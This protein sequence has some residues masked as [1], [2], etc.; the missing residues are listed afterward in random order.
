RCAALGSNR[1]VDFSISIAVACDSEA[2]TPSSLRAKAFPRRDL[3]PGFATTSSLI[4][5]RAQGMPGARRTH[6]L[7]CKTKKQTSVVTTGTPKS[8]G[9]PCAMALR[10]LRALPG[11]SGLLATVADR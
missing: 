4:D 8:L 3:R 11:V 6:S 2:T 9:T 10:L 7:V 1:T 5:E